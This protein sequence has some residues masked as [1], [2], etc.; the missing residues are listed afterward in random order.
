MG[1]RPGITLLLETS[2]LFL[3]TTPP[4]EIRAFPLI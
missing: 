1:R 2:I 4:F 3:I